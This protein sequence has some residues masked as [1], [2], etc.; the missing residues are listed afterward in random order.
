MST[1]THK[2]R[3]HQ[4]SFRMK[5]AVL[6]G[7]SLT[8][9]AVIVAVLT[10]DDEYETG[11]QVCAQ[12]HERLIDGGTITFRSFGGQWVGTDGDTDLHFTD[13]RNIVMIEYGVGVTTYHGTYEISQ[14]GV[15][16]AKFAGF[17]SEWPQ[18]IIGRDDRSLVLTTT[19]KRGFVFG[20]RG[21][22][23]LSS[24]DGPYWPFRP[25]NDTEITQRFIKQSR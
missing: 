25:T 11:P 15:I 19:A 12:F 7:T 18:M 6:V 23:V 5:A 2:R 22:A 1:T 3:W 17:P 4:F 13:D 10:M 20:G 24:E 21:G 16:D 9:V 8:I 14:N